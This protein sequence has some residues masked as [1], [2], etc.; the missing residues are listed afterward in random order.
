MKEG[1]GTAA[2]RTAAHRN[3]EAPR[4]IAW[5]ERIAFDPARAA[6]AEL[7]SGERLFTGLNCLLPGQGQERH[8]HAAAD[9]LYVVLRG[10]G[11]FEVG[12]DA[13][14]AGE[15]TVVPAPAGVPHGVRNE[16]PEPLVLMTVM[17]PPP[18]KG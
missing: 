7:W 2:D 5:V 16:G 9:K 3:G 12:E 6:K 15:G 1:G 8:S 4:A 13:F 18:R 10:R 14:A 11:A 17:S